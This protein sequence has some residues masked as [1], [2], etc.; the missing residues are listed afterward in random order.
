[1]HEGYIAAKLLQSGN[2]LQGCGQGIVAPMGEKHDLFRACFRHLQR[3]LLGASGQQEKHRRWL[4]RQFI[5]GSWN[6][7]HPCGFTKPLDH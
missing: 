3:G 1:M 7:F 4:A 2:R 6:Q 5:L